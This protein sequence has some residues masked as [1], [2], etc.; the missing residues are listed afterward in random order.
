MVNSDAV[1]GSETVE[2]FQLSNL[3]SEVWPEELLG[4]WLATPEW[5]A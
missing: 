2:K 5:R 3:L 1:L 4:T